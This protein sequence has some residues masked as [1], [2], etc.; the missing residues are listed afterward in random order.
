MVCPARSGVLPAA[1]RSNRTAPTAGCCQPSTN[2][3]QRKMQVVFF[4]YPIFLRLFFY[5]DIS[6]HS[7]K[8]QHPSALAKFYA[9]GYV[10]A[11]ERTMTGA[12]LHV[13]YYGNGEGLCV[14]IVG[15]KAPVH[16]LELYVGREVVGIG[17]LQRPVQ[18]IIAGCIGRH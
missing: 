6:V 12:F 13:L 11:V 15:K 8:L 10:Q 2:K 16:A 14:L 17:D 4:S 18:R 3:Y 9:S 7:F 5:V 1:L